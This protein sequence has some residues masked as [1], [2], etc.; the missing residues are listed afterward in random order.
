ML[1]NLY[2]NLKDLGYNG[3]VNDMLY[4]FLEDEG[5]TGALNDM[6]YN[7]LDDLG[8]EGSITDK[9][10]RWDESL[11]KTP[12]ISSGTLTFPHDLTSWDVRVDYNDGS[13]VKWLNQFTNDNT[14]KIPNDTNAV[15]VLV[16]VSKNSSYF[17]YKDKM[18]CLF[19]ASQDA[20]GSIPKSYGSYNMPS[21]TN[22]GANNN[23][24]DNGKYITTNNRG[25]GSVLN[26]PENL[27]NTTIVMT[28]RQLGAN[29][30][31]DNVFRMLGSNYSVVLE[32]GLSTTTAGSNFR[33][34]S[35]QSPFIN[36]N[37]VVQQT[38]AFH[39]IV[40]NFNRNTNEVVGWVDGIKTLENNFT[41]VSLNLTR[42]NIGDGTNGF[43]SV[44]DWTEFAVFEDLTEEELKQIRNEAQDRAHPLIKDYHL[45]V[46]G[47]SY[48]AV[49][50]SWHQAVADDLDN[51]LGTKIYATG[52]H[53]S[54]DKL[55]QL[56]QLEKVS[57]KYA[58]LYIGENDRFTGKD[59][60]A[61]ST[62]RTINLVD[63]IP[64]E[65]GGYVRLQGTE[66]DRRIVA[67][68]ASSITVSPEFNTL[69]EVGKK[70][71]TS[72]K[73][74][75]ELLVNKIR[76]K[77]CPN[78][79]VLTAHYRNFSITDDGVGD[80][81]S[82]PNYFNQQNSQ[83]SLRNNQIAA[84]DK[85]GAP[86]VYLAELFSEDIINGTYTQG[87]DVTTYYIAVNDSHPTAAGHAI[88]ITPYVQDAF[89][90]LGWT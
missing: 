51:I 45:A 9:K 17:D 77:G 11:F 46:F 31:Q 84:A 24:V 41:G 20:G 72:V 68:D 36:K 7:Y 10:Y 28:V 57:A 53:N 25:M 30:P 56:D 6:L 79:M 71:F 63:T 65:V 18:K 21:L 14:W 87:T 76:E 85:V 80:F 27:N 49:V 5:Y 48:T 78:V 39:T 88:L 70:M 2:K 58:V 83:E 55:L 62:K 66:E 3:Q 75:I 37:M 50:D 52:G 38:K 40:I 12:N 81:S 4:T 89:T 43:E 8:Y 15:K 23:V 74:M 90:E 26:T 42:I 33:L 35:F 54:H 59:I 29:H 67:K 13:T 1:Q 60:L 82:A 61:G 34:R 69:P 86:Y 19:M 73:R 16:K 32:S 44:L 64:Y 47:D 22:N